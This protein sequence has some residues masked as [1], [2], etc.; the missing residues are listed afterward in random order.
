MVRPPVQKRITANGIAR[1]ASQNPYLTTKDRLWS[2]GT[3]FNCS[4]SPAQGQPSWKSSEG[5]LSTVLAAK[6]SIRTWQKN[7][8]TEQK[9]LA[10]MSKCVFG[11]QMAQNVHEEN[12]CP[13]VKH[14][15]GLIMF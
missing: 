2:C 15:E 5:N 14:R 9:S 10:K 7:I 4:V 11:E 3:L 6:F 13:S 8:S 1:K 12:T